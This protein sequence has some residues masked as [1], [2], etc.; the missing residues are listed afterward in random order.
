[1][2]KR[3]HAWDALVAQTD[4]PFDLAS[5]ID[6]VESVERAVIE[7][8]LVG[9]YD[10]LGQLEQEVDGRDA[11]QFQLGIAMARRAIR[12]LEHLWLR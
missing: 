6:S 3:K 9:V 10:E 8:F 2:S 4:T 7:D 1:M 12:Q 5:H 11:S